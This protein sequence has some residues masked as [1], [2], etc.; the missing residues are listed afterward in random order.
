MIV[1]LTIV[2]VLAFWAFLT[3]LAVGLLLVFKTLEAIRGQLERIAFGVRAIENEF[4]RDIGQPIAIEQ[5]TAP[6]EHLAGELP[7]AAENAQTA[8]QRLAQR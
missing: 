7:V 6:L 2:S 3:E 4:D 5:Q 1:I 8:L